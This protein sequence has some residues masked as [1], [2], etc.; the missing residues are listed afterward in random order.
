[1][2]NPGNQPFVSVILPVYNG[3]AIFERAVRSVLAQTF[4]DW[5]LLA[6]DDGSTDETLR[7]LHSWAARDA[8]IRV[9]QLDENG[10]GHS[11]DTNRLWSFE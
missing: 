5:E 8:R 9:I 4:A 3:A 10:E 2:T 7:T 6:V 1:M 11:G